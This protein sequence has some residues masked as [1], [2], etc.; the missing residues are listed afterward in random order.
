MRFCGLVTRF[1]G[2]MLRVYCLIM[3]FY[4]LLLIF[5]GLVIRF[6]GLVMIFYGVVIRLY[7]L[8]QPQLSGQLGLV[9]TTVTGQ[10]LTAVSSAPTQFIQPTVAATV[11]LSSTGQGL[12]PMQSAAPM[13]TQPR[14][15]T[16]PHV[17]TLT[18]ETRHRNK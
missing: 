4:G 18:D 6:Y 5:Y 17:D 2:F 15:P 3:R 12:V 8:F 16:G 11:R 9:Q 13:L 7:G 10:G 1:Y 14:Q